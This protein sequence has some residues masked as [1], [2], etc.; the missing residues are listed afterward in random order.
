MHEIPTDKLALQVWW[1]LTWRT[2]PLAILGG[3]AVGV[4]IGVIVAVM[5]ADKDA[6]Q[7]PATL[8]GGLVGLFITVKVIK[9]LMT[10][11]F[12]EYRLTVVKK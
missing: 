6:V 1:A 2:I 10:K 7:M 8:G 4:V 12:G 3:I 9:Y 5:Q 11:G